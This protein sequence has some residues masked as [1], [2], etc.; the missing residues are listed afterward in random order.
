MF[1]DKNWGHSV[2]QISQDLGGGGTGSHQ[3]LVWPS[4]GIH[5]GLDVWD[6]GDECGT[7]V[8]DVA[9]SMSHR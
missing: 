8:D 9:V 6:E 4:V 2:M 3:T 1:A 5:Y 7:R